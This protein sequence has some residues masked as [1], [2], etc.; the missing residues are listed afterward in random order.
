[1]I[2]DP[3]DNIFQEVDLPNFLYFFFDFMI[4]N[5]KVASMN[6]EK[7]FN[8]VIEFCQDML[9]K[10]KINNNQ[11]SYIICNW[12]NENKGM[13]ILRELNLHNEFQSHKRGQEKGHIE[14][15]FQ[16]GTIQDMIK[17]SQIN[18]SELTKEIEPI[19]KIF[20]EKKGIFDNWNGRLSKFPEN[21]NLQRETEKAAKDMNDIQITLLKYQQQIDSHNQQIE[22][23]NQEKNLLCDQFKI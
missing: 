22:L 5:I 14:A 17:E 13:E 4:V 12:T 2:L 6:E 21:K 8:L 10:N 23:W 16:I 15:E 3:K 11:Y 18:I 7:S 20:D 9:C 19:Q 1:M